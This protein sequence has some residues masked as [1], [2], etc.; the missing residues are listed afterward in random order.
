MQDRDYTAAR[1]AIDKAAKAKD[2]PSDYLA[3]LR[4]WSL[5]LDKQYD[6]AIAAFDK[7]EKD[8]PQS[9]WLRR[10][11]FAKT[12]AMVGKGDF[13]GAQAIYEQEAKYLLSDG[14]RQQSAEVYLE[15][16]DARFQPPRESQKPDYD[17]ARQ[18]YALALENG[19]SGSRRA[20]VEFR[21]GVCLQK[22]GAFDEAAKSFADFLARHGDDLRQ[23]EIRYRLGEC[24][25]AAGKPVDARK[26]WRELLSGLHAPAPIAKPAGKSRDW[27][28]EAAFHLA[29]TWRCPQPRDDDDL[30]RGVAALRDFL[31]RFPRHELAGQAHLAIAASQIY[32]KHYDAAAA[33]LQN[34]LRDPRWKDCKEL[35]IAQRELGNVLLTQK[36]YSDA[37]ATW[38]EYLARY[39]AD[40]GWSA[41]QR[42]VIDAEY[43]MGLEKVKTGDYDSG[44]RLLA[45]FAAHYPLD[46]RNPGI[47]L[48]FGEIQHRQK[49]WE[50]AVGAWQRL[51]EKYP[52]ASEAR[53]AE[54]L[55]ARTLDEQ[56]GRYDEAREHYK[57]AGDTA[58]AAAISARQM[59]VETPR[60]FRSDETPQLKLATRNVPAVKVRAYKIDLESYFRKM[61]TVAGI[62]RL[63]VSLID[64]DATFEF[65][66]PGFAKYKPVTSDV[67]VPLPGRLNAGVAAVTVTSTALEATTL[68]IQSDLE[69]VVRASP[70][71]AIV[72]AENM[73]TGKPWAGVRLLLSDGKSVFA[74]GKTGDDGTFVQ[75]L[76]EADQSY[77]LRVFAVADDGHVASTAVHLAQGSEAVELA[78]R[79]TVATDRAEYRAGEPVHVRGCARHVQSGQLVIEPGKK[80]SVE[81]F[82]SADRRLRR[83]SVTLSALGTF[84]CDFPLPA[85][86][87]D[88]NYSVVVSDEVGHHRTA[89]FEI[90][91]PVEEVGRLAIDLP[92]HVYYRGE[93]VE[94]TFRV[95]LPQDR[96]LSNA[97]VE[98]RLDNLPPATVTTDAH[99]E[100]RFNIATEE[101]QGADDR[102]LSAA[103][104]SR[105]LSAQCNLTVATH[106]FSIGL[107]AAR[108][109]FVAGE[110]VEVKVKTADAAN[111]PIAEKLLVK[112]TRQVPQGDETRDEP[113]EEHAA[114]T[115]VDGTARVHARS[116][117]GRKL[118]DLCQRQ[119]PLRE[120][121]RAVI[122][123]P[124]IGRRRSRA[125]A[126][127]RRS[128]GPQGG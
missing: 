96:P 117:Q 14:R 76:A 57:K 9:R 48:L 127:A 3:Y 8:Y 63:D 26:A 10:A 36:K 6:Q 7:I 98:Y 52:H 79:L 102:L 54:V 60:V 69:I 23:N 29:E 28:A 86:M 107:S 128:R 97:K 77:I 82:D 67:P 103:V 61:H 59:L 66:V 126:V 34:F 105:G 93:P 49:K 122:E 50:T 72:F 55:I 114:T 90:A 88:G 125:I 78:D 43:A 104:S 101:L 41:V 39:P 91:L 17:A 110:S 81:M 21:I 115:G 65:A 15:F 53:S 38:R 4:A 31:A 1:I 74:E 56:L 119:R 27:P 108:P 51:V 106:G 5:H 92:R 85:G 100:A 2:A 40:E 30:R 68:L 11:R 18:L 84:A 99:G 25:L 124:R 24:L 45:D 83:K 16:G 113:V 37:L 35:P 64:P 62:E 44:T 58:A 20:D 13:R 33:T 112:V 32:R 120:R 118:H 111:Q 95:L 22:L 19:L 87:P 116:R 109:V 71:E 80:L 12:Q 75:R 89:Q 47:L 73:R 46:D 70:R 121:D 123:D 42:S 94:G